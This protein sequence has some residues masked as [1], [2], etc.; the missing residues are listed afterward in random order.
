MGDDEQVD[1][2][3]NIE[4]IFDLIMFRDEEQSACRAHGLFPWTQVNKDK[5]GN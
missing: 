2:A 1:T 4:S 5:V 3:D